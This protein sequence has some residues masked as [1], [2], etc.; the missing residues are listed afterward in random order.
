MSTSG[1]PATPSSSSATYEETLLS[2]QAPDPEHEFFDL[3]RLPPAQRG[4]AFETLFFRQLQRVTTR[5]HDTEN[6][7]QIMLDRKS[8]V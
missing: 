2:H 7:E 4:A 3:Q 5:I 6:V 8:V 1:R